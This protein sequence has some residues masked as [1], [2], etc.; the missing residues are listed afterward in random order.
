MANQNALLAAL[1]VAQH[2]HMHFGD[3]RAGGIEHFQ[4]TLLGILLHR[5]GNA[6][7]RE[8]DNHIV[9]HFM[10][11]FHEDR[12]AF[13]QGFYYKAV[14]H[15]FMANVNRRAED[16]QRA[17]DDINRAVDTRTKPARVG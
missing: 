8:D 10:E 16:I 6:V 13:T 12:A 17:V 2:F 14:V 1:G 7:G 11:L 3:Q 5:P 4:A 15:H 9:G